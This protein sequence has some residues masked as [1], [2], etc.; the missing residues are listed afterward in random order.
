MILS[1]LP[2]NTILNVV[3]ILNGNEENSIL[4]VESAIVRKYVQPADLPIVSL[5]DD[6]NDCNLDFILSLTLAIIKYYNLYYNSYL[7]M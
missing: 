6:G 7:Y 2:N 4:E 5:N 1:Y 3:T